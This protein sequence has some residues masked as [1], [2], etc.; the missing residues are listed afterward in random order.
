MML[1]MTWVRRFVSMCDRLFRPAGAGEDFTRIIH[2]R[3]TPWA[4]IFRPLRGLRPLSAHAGTASA[5][6]GTP[7]GT[8]GQG[9]PSPYNLW[10]R[11][12]RTALPVRNDGPLVHSRP[13]N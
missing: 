9:K 11:L 4:T 6:T 10:S 2:P 13:A 8:L 7:R 3:L 5:R 1:R 12:R